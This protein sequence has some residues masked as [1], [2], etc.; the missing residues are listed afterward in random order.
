VFRSNSLPPG[1]C[2]TRI[3]AVVWRMTILLGQFGLTVDTTQ[4]YHDD[5]QQMSRRVIYRLY[6]MREREQAVACYIIRKDVGLWPIFAV[7]ACRPYVARA[8]ELEAD[9]GW[10]SDTYPTIGGLA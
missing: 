4:T 1:R 8:G 9:L 5:M 2:S 10:G 7:I 6:P 3:D